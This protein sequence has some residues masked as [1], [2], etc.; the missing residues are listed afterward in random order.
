MFRGEKGFNLVEVMIALVVVLLVSLAMMQTALLSIDSN[1]SNVLRDEAVSLAE[2]RM[3]IDR[4]LALSTTD[5]DLNLSQE[6]VAVPVDKNVRNATVQYSARRTVNNH[7]LANPTTKE[8]IETVTWTWKGQ[9]Y[10][11]SGRTLLKR[12]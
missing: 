5:F 7:P 1:M 12:P 4:N 10:T 11:Y 2:E 9:N 8:V 6:A 3:S